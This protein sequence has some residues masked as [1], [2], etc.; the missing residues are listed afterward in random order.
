MSDLLLV[1]IAVATALNGIAAGASLD[2]SIKQ[3]P[4][5]HRIGVVAYATYSQAGDLGNGL[6]WYAGLGICAVLVS[7]ATTI[8]AIVQR[9]RPQHALPIFLVSA[10]WA[11]HM[12]ITLTLA[13]PTL[14]SQRRADAIEATLA[15]VFNRFERIQTIR[16]LLDVLIFGITLWALLSYVC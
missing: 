11:L 12:L 16:V 3:L 7:L 2:Q 15:A 13:A 14:R 9:T 1:L 4:A 5:R 6:F 10:V 8:V